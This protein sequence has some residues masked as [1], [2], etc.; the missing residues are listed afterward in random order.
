MINFP[1]SWQCRNN[2][3]ANQKLSEKIDYS[4]VLI[5]LLAKRN[6][7][8]E[9]EI[10]SFLNPT[11]KNLHDSLKLP[12]IRKGI[13]RIKEVINKKENVLI[14]GDYDADGVISAS[15]MYKFLKKLDLNAEVYIPDRFNEGYDLNLDFF[16]KISMQGKY[17]LII[18]VDCGTNS[19]EVQKFIQNNP[20]PDVIVCDHHNHSTDF[21]VKQGSYI[22]INPMLKGSRYPFKYLSGAGVTFK[23][24]IAV[25]RELEDSHKKKF[26]DNYL[27]TLLDLVAISTIAD[28]M[29]LIDENRIMVKK[30]LKMLQ[31]TINPGLKKMINMVVKNK[32]NINEHDIGF[33]I[34]PRLNAAGRIKNAESSF[35][36]LIKEGD[37]LDEIVSDLNLFNTQRQSIQKDILSEI[38]ENND[39]NKIITK[40]KIF[41]DKSK[42]WNEGVLGIVASDIVKRFNIPAILFRESE[43]KLKGSGR[44]TDKFDLYGNLIS[45]SNLFNSFGGHRA[46]CGISMDVLNF[47]AF[48]QKMVEIVDKNFKISDTEKKN[49]Y[50]LELDF[51]DI[52][53][54]ILR[55]INMLRPFG[56]GN[57]KPGFV[58]GN[59]VIMDFCYLMEEKHVKL[60]LR[61]SGVII[62]AIIFGVEEKMKEKIIK[63]NK[64]NIL[65]K[66]EE[67]IWGDFKKVQLVIS[68][69]F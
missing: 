3:K 55:E 34:A 40:K 7:I 30:G 36:L 69:L 60:K 13:K 6:I 41:I 4:S 49:I 64:V 63:G 23:F 46:A 43:G 38:M 68:D 11:L 18:C 20:G 59:C 35:D 27:T 21:D 47:D 8:T 67:N 51:K 57:P 62:D 44:S 10:V 25:L 12:G 14:F 50:D 17:D 5:E 32:E 15:L 22:I 28:L 1:A 45:C 19:V 58:T 53:K 48:Y 52:S 31:K 24:I 29:P 16:K 54:K 39:F 66:I 65:Y 33:I 56:A 42:D 9:E 37:I 61:Q 2:K 26:A